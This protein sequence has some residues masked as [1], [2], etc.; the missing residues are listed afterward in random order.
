MQEVNWSV[1]QAT[2]QMLACKEAIRPSMPAQAGEM[3]KVISREFVKLYRAL[4]Q[5][6]ADI[7]D[8]HGK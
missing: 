2:A 6:A 8:G 4:E 7:R 3:D 1:F 5:A